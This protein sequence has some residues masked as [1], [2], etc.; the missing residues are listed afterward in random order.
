MLP[1]VEEFIMPR[2]KRG[3]AATQGDPPFKRGGRGTTRR[4]SG[5]GERVPAVN[6][7]DPALRDALRFPPRLPDST[8]S[9]AMVGT[10]GDD[11]EGN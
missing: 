6:K 9:I 5:S 4:L 2:T 7:D 1:P 3:P 8:A 11:E 10:A